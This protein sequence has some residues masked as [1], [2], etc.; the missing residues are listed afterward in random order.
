MLA[1]KAL[2]QQPPR[3]SFQKSEKKLLENPS[4]DTRRPSADFQGQT[5]YNNHNRREDV[6]ASRRGIS[7][8]C[9]VG[10]FAVADQAVA[11]ILTQVPS[12]L[13]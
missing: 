6:H 10:V 2:H 9:R 11:L 1:F 4:R 12:A 13:Y 3:T 7:S 8:G 5:R